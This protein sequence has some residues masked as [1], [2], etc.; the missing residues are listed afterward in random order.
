QPK[1]FGSLAIAAVFSRRLSLPAS[2]HRCPLPASRRQLYSSPSQ[3]ISSPGAPNV[4]FYRSLDISKGLG[5]EE[6]WS[7]ISG[8]NLI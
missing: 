8:W 2:R 3:C 5:V 6:G 4:K 7:R 1:P